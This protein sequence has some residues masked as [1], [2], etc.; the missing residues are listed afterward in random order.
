MQKYTKNKNKKKTSIKSK[1]T[2]ATQNDDRYFNYQYNLAFDIFN[3]ITIKTELQT[4][5]KYFYWIVSPNYNKHLDTNKYTLIH[6]LLYCLMRFNEWKQQDLIQKYVLFPINFPTKIN[7]LKNTKYLNLNSFNYLLYL[8]NFIYYLLEINQSMDIFIKESNLDKWGYN[9]SI[10][11]INNKPFY[12]IY[13]V[14]RAKTDLAKS[15]IILSNNY[16]KEFV[17]IHLANIK[18]FINNNRQRLIKANLLTGVYL[19]T[20]NHNLKKLDYNNKFFVIND[21]YIPKCHIE[22]NDIQPIEVYMHLLRKE[23]NFPTQDRLRILANNALKYRNVSQLT[24]DLNSADVSIKNYNEM[25]RN[26]KPL[27]FDTKTQYRNFIHDIAKIV[28][29]RFNDFTIK[30]LG[31]GTTFYSSSP[32]IEKADRY[33]SYEQSDIDV[34]IIPNENFDKY[35]PELEALSEGKYFFSVGVFVNPLTRSF[36]G[37]ELMSKF[38]NKW[39][40]QEL[41]QFPDIYKPIE[42]DKTILKRH[43]SITITAKKDLFQYFDVI[44]NNQTCLPNF[45]T[46]IKDGK[47]MSYWN[48]NNEYITEHI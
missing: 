2:R 20:T 6:F 19:F 22:I 33:F 34:N 12:N 11:D 40:P 23:I 21:L 46:F 36:L 15:V 42:I 44:K 41:G 39:G 32:F 1:K 29:T 14:N 38:F 27:G 48:E 10:I 13:F 9:V 26:I 17:D 28:K 25:I 18:K 35:K 45:S 8:N 30:S 4:T 3:D 47:T 5:D 43:I 31:S 16:P 24:K 7:F 37:E